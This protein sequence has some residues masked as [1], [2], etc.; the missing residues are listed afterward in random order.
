MLLYNHHQSSALKDGVNGFLEENTFTNLGAP[1]QAMM[2]GNLKFGLISNA[3]E[4]IEEITGYPAEHFV[5]GGITALLEILSLEDRLA[6]LKLGASIG[7]NPD[8][9]NEGKD[10]TPSRKRRIRLQ[11][12]EGHW[13]TAEMV[14]IVLDFSKDGTAGRVLTIIRSCAGQPA[15]A[16][17]NGKSQSP[18][19]SFPHR[20]VK[21]SKRERQVLRLIAHGLSS[22]MVADRLCISIHTAARH[23]ANLLDKFKVKN[24][25]ELVFR[26]SRRFSL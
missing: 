26:A 23:R 17:A 5:T 24:T 11:H 9:Q 14:V 20:S 8:H 10:A 6:L 4:S 18:A 13:I 7:Q 21:I 3:S 19:S 22:K 12:C 25:A 2:L 15:E 16:K 1:Y